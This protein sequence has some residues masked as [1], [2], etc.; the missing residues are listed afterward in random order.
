MSP[1]DPD[2]SRDNSNLLTPADAEGPELAASTPAVGNS[3]AQWV[4][5]SARRKWVWAVCGALVLIVG[6]V[7]AQ[8]YRFEFINIDDDRYVHENPHIR[9]GLSVDG[10]KWAFLTVLEREYYPLTS[11]SHMV[12]CQLFGLNPAGTI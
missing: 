12:D 11:I 8:T 5:V 9:S 6:A 3:L 2:E 4:D 1:S 10:L 7:F